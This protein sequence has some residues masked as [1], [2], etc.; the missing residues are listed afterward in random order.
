MSYFGLNIAGSAIDAFQTAENITADNIANINTPGSS[1]QVAS[2]VQ[3]QPVV[4]S[5][6]MLSNPGNVQPGTRGDGVIVDKILRIHQDSYDGLFRGAT[7]SQNYYNTEQST[8][9]GL[10]S[11]L[12]EPSNGINTAYTS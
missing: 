10:Q 2:I 12:G 9:D 1:R 6:F 5:P 4:G 11:A 3:Q 7:A 8:L